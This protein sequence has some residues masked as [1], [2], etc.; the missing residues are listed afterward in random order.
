MLHCHPGNGRAGLGAGSDNLQF[1]FG[2][3]EPSLGDLGG[4]SLAR[5][6]VHDVHRAHYL[7]ISAGLQCV[8]A[9]RIPLIRER[10]REGIA[11]AKQRGAY[12]GR[13]KALLPEQGAELGFVALTVK[14]LA[15]LC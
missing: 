6:G 14:Q 13:K 10:Q 9:G 15:R 7:W 12:R 3:V 4:A 8:F 5:N 2:T 1:E 11:L